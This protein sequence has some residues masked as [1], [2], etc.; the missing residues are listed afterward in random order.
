VYDA[1]TSERP[2]KKAWPHHEAIAWI[3]E[4]AGTH[5]DPDLTASFLACE[6]AVD[7][8]RGGLADEPQNDR[9]PVG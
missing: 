1:L 3:R 7:R 5:F 6:A 2:Y 9:T 8:I 4:R